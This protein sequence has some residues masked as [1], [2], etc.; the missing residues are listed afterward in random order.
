VDPSERV[1]SLI[2]AYNAGDIEGVLTGIAIDIEILI[3]LYRLGETAGP[4]ALNGKEEFSRLLTIRMQS[5][6]GITALSLNHDG[7]VAFLTVESV[8]QGLLSV[9]IR[10]DD[11]GLA[12]RLV[13]FKQ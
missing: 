12:S 10:F 1:T 7:N 5:N 2:G 11:Q 4:P 6:R 8:L 9:V 13:V 3:P